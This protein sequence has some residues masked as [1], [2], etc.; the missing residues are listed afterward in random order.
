M[1]AS[2]FLHDKEEREKEKEK[3]KKRNYRQ[4][5]LVQTQQVDAFDVFRPEEF[6]IAVE[7]QRSH[8]FS[9]VCWRPLADGL[10]VF[11]QQ[12]ERESERERKWNK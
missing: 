4:F 12:R 3:K 5:V 6:S 8:P 2:I 1:K 9:H 11:Q 7:V 10:H